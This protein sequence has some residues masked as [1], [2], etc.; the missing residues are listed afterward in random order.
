[1]PLPIDASHVLLGREPAGR[2]DAIRIIGELMIARGEVT[3]RY[4]E[5]MLEKEARHGTWL[6][7]GVALPH[8]TNE[9]K[10]EVR[11]ASLVV[12]QMPKGVDWGGKTVYLA[13]GVASPGD[14]EH[15]RLLS[16]LA[17]VLMRRELVERMIQATDPQEIVA[18]LASEAGV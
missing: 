7:D 12:L 11:A 4:L 17:A 9:V 5:G 14:N 6:T 10:S 18:I 8:G 3:L 15:L 16:A 2:E 1:V 13:F